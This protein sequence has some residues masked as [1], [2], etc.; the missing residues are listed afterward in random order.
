MK[1]EK[2]NYQKHPA[3]FSYLENDEEIFNFKKSKNIAQS[4]IEAKAKEE[5]EKMEK[6]GLNPQDLMYFIYN[7][8]QAFKLSS[9]EEDIRYDFILSMHSFL[10]KICQTYN[11][12]TSQLFNYLQC[13]INRRRQSENKKLAKIGAKENMLL[14]DSGISLNLLSKRDRYQTFF[15]ETEEEN[16]KIPKNLDEKTI[17][18]LPTLALK[19]SWYLNDII[20]EKL[21]K[22]CSLNKENFIKTV[23]KLNE[24]LEKRI[25]HKEKNCKYLAALYSRHLSYQYEMRNLEG[26]QSAYKEILQKRLNRGFEIWEKYSSYKKRNRIS[27]PVALIAEVLNRPIEEIKND[28]RYFQRHRKK[29]L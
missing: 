29:F 17:Q 1:T 25:E 19:S 15:N 22:L 16:F 28:L 27:T 14:F 4:K 21:C 20:I 2:T 8:F 9:M 10:D 11:P 23:E 5:L 3:N 13:C 24:K 18:R 12:N 6:N 7:N 26:E